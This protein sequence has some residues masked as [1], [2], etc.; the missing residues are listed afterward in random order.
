MK[1]ICVVTSYLPFTRGGNEV[2]AET[3]ARQL[4]RFGYRAQLIMVPQNRFGR[5][6]SAYMAAFLTDVRFKNSLEETDQV[7]SLRFPSFAVRHPSHV[8]W[9]NHRMR[10]YYD[11]WDDF[12][13]RLGS[14]SQLVKEKLRR[15]MI[16]SLDRYLLK[17]HVTK[18]FAQSRNIQQRL[19]DWGRIRSEVLYPPA[20]DLLR[21]RRWR[22]GNFILVPGR[23]DRLKRQDLLIRALRLFQK[24]R[25]YAIIAGAGIE[26]Q[27]LKSLAESLGLARKVKFVGQLDY[28]ALSRYYADCLAV[29]YGPLNE[30]YGLV[31]LEAF[32][33]HKP[34]ITCSDSGGPTELVESGVTGY[35]TEPDPEAIAEAIGRLA[36]DNSLARSLGEAAHQVSLK[37]SWEEAISKLVSV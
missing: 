13:S 36:A 29:Y 17:H 7:I 10:D 2:L 25:L 15:R 37:H 35:V 30:D 11:L 8:C 24:G 33:C 1:K 28:K 5:Q 23:L 6:L 12:S 4:E 20:T 31:T 27:R 34:V 21:C 26:E 32:G 14:A 16:H 9:L 18:L 19:I 3:L 22:Y